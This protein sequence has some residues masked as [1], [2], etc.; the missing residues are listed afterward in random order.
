MALSE[1]IRL[2]GS[3]QK[4]N[5]NIK[6]EIS[7]LN[8]LKRGVFLK[9][10]IKK[11]TEI[12][13]NDLYFSFPCSQGQMRANNLSKNLKIFSKQN[14]KKDSPLKLSNIKI[15]D[16]YSKVL[17]IR[18]RIKSFLRNSGVILPKN[19]RLEIS[20]HY[21]IDKFSKFGLTMIN[22][23][24]D[25]YCKKLLILLPGQKH[26]AQYHRIKKVLYYMEQ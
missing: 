9:R 12:N 8:L 24:N 2:W 4:R 17:I 1:S 18:D 14:Q 21:G 15:T 22:V 11:N 3:N 10:N 25:K 20:F 13:F 16:T 23:I 26:P 19:P 7:Q 6:S 5:Q